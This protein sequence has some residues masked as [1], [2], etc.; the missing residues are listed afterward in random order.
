LLSKRKNVPEEY[1]NLRD[2]RVKLRRLKQKAD[3]FFRSDWRSEFSQI[4]SN[5]AVSY[6]QAKMTPDNMIVTVVGEI[7]EF[8]KAK[9]RNG[10]KYGRMTISDEGL[11]LTVMMWSNKLEEYKGKFFGG[12]A[13][14]F[15][16]S[17][18]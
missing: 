8:K 15:E 1:E 11:N 7:Q 12:N 5:A 14:S 9:S 17:F 13:F 18:L 6:E 4:W 2:D 16:H 10:N 3:P